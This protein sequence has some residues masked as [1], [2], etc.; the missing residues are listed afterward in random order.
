MKIVLTKTGITVLSTFVIDD[1]ELEGMF[2][3]QGTNLSY[4]ARKESI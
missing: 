3:E 4:Y 2:R 1:D